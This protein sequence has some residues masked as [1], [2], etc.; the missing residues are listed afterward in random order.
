MLERVYLVYYVLQSVHIL[1]ESF[2][3]D[4]ECINVSKQILQSLHGLKRKKK[5]KCEVGCGSAPPLTG[6]VTASS[7]VLDFIIIK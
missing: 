1:P 3:G 4:L 5:G 7:Q 2:S 6:M